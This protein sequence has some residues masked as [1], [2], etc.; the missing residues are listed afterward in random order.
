M[1]HRALACG[2]GPPI[3]PVT[4]TWPLGLSLTTMGVVGG[5]A[6]KLTYVGNWYYY[7]GQ[8]KLLKPPANCGFVGK[9]TARPSIYIVVTGWSYDPPHSTIAKP[10]AFPN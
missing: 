4:R 1:V 9:I 10:Y 8:R 3:P 6:G 2:M 5:Y 7:F